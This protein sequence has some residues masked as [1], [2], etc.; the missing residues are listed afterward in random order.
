MNDIQPMVVGAVVPCVFPQYHSNWPSGA[1]T[2]GSSVGRGVSTPRPNA[3]LICA[4]SYVRPNPSKSW[5]WY[6]VTIHS[7]LKLFDVAAV[8]NHFAD[9]LLA[10]RTTLVTP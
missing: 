5:N 7:G 3:C 2:L 1:G 4:W 8:V 10:K 6:P 9:V